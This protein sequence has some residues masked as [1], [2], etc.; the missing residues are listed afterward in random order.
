[1]K[2]RIAIIYMGYRVPYPIY[3]LDTY[4]ERCIFLERLNRFVARVKCSGDLESLAHLNNTGRLKDLLTPGAEVLCSGIQGSKLKLRIIGTI[5]DRT[6]GTLIDTKLQERSFIESIKLGYI[7]WLKN[8]IR[9]M[10]DVDVGGSKIDL[11]LESVDR[12]KIYIELKSAVYFFRHD[13]SA[14]YPD[15]ISLRGRKHIVELANIEGA[16]RIVVFIAAHPY[17]SKFKPSRDDPEISS[18]LKYASSLGV[19]IRSVKIAINHVEKS[20]VLLDPDL[21]VELSY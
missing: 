5:V 1:M 15:T 3:R 11:Y 13:H 7:P 10:R 17:A 21:P 8:I 12:N 2:P 20:I 16:R 14:R 6:W 19:E 18:I 9:I 4:I